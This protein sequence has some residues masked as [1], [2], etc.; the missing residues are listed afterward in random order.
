M[1]GVLDVHPSV[2]G[3]ILQPPLIN[4]SNEFPVS[5]GGSH[6]TIAQHPAMRSELGESLSNYELQI[7]HARNPRPGAADGLVVADHP[8]TKVP[9]IAI[10]VP[11]TY[12][13]IKA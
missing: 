5:W 12:V 6:P 7:S 1:V 2:A 11:L 4:K 10:F 13:H 9:W 3:E 8:L